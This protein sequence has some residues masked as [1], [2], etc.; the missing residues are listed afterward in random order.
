MLDKLDDQHFIA[1]TLEFVLYTPNL[2]TKT[3]ALK[4][5]SDEGNVW[6]RLSVKRKRRK[7]SDFASYSQHFPQSLKVKFGR[8]VGA[9]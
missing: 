7:Y 9:V 8:K 3:K 1:A 2:N 5:F 6:R 4:G